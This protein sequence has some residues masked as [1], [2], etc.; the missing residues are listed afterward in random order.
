MGVDVDSA[1]MFSQGMNKGTV[2]PVIIIKILIMNTYSFYVSSASP[3]DLKTLGS[4]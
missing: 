1:S 4:Q 2:L 3:P